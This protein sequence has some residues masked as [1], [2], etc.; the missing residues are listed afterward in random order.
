[1]RFFDF[2]VLTLVSYMVVE[3]TSCFK[4]AFGVEKRNHV[5]SILSHLGLYN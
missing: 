2:R 5:F 3:A 1:M 4:M